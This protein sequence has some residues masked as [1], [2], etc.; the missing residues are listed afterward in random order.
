MSSAAALPES[1]EAWSNPSLSFSAAVVM[2]EATHQAGAILLRKR[3]PIRD[4]IH[5]MCA[6]FLRIRYSEIGRMR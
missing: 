1:I 2:F 6:E 3:T 4:F 5:R